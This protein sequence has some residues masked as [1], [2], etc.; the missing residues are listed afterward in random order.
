MK[1]TFEKFIIDNPNYIE[2]LEDTYNKT[3]NRFVASINTTAKL[4]LPSKVSD[5]A[6]ELRPTQENAISRII[7]NKSTLL[8]HTA[9]LGK[10]FTDGCSCN[11]IKA[12]W[13]I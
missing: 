10:T 6:I 3:F 8:D 2:I 1:D 4:I 9:G 5:D 13:C 12:Y 7:N 11:G